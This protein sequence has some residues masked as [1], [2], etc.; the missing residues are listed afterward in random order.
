MTVVYIFIQATRNGLSDVCDFLC[1]HGA[2]P[3]MGDLTGK[4]PFDECKFMLQDKVS[5][6]GSNISNNNDLMEQY[7]KIGKV[8]AQ[9]QELHPCSE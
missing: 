3:N 2:S 6:S 8:F 5:R 1:K 4:T 7:N 9:Y